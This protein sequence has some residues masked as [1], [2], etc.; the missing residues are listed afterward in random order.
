MIHVVDTAMTMPDHETRGAIRGGGAI[1][2][3]ALECDNYDG[4]LAGIS[5]AGLARTL[6]EV[7]QVQVRQIFLTDP[8]DVLIELNF[9][10][11][12]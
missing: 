9:R 6:N 8:N 2:H 7:P 10:G 12:A 3:V 11:R 1:H 4:T 5:A